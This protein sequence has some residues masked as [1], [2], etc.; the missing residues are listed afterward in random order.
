MSHPMTTS[1]IQRWLDA[2]PFIQFLGLRCDVADGEAGTLCMSMP[3]REELERGAGGQQFHGGPI[4][5]LID[6]AGC[7]AI[8][9]GTR[10]PVPT[11][12]FRVDYLRPSGGRQLLAQ[13]RV[14][15][16]GKTVGVVDVDVLDDQ[17]RLTA[18]GRG[19]FGIPSA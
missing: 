4:A 13:A 19:C 5:S 10:A 7:F 14:R 3:M 2:S 1:E 18:V 11:I 6:T 16:A 12:N 9:M 8:I 17:G 15:R